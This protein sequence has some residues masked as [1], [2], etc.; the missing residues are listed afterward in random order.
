MLTAFS[1]LA[2]RGR[3]LGPDGHGRPHGDDSGD[4]CDELL[5]DLDLRFRVELAGEIDFAVTDL[6]LDHSGGQP[7]HPPEHLVANLGG[8]HVIR[9]DERADQVC[10]SDDSDQASVL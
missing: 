10:P 2:A 9:A 5:E 7:E 8:D 4:L 3:W 6:D 1:S